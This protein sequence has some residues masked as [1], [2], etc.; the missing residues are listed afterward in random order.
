MAVREGNGYNPW[1][2]KKSCKGVPLAR[3][4][5]QPR[6][7]IHSTCP[8]GCLSKYIHPTFSRVI[9]C[10]HRVQT[11]GSAWYRIL[12]FSLPLYAISPTA[13]SGMHAPQWMVAPEKTVDHCAGVHKHSGAL[14][15][16]EE[17]AIRG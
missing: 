10:L 11:G 9:S 13:L 4:I 6:H 3:L 15:R 17:P 1:R 5:V 8:R 2:C 7:S 14:E 12:P 16:E